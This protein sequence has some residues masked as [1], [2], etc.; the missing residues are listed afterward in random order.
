MSDGEASHRFLKLTAGVMLRGI[1][2][3]RLYFL[4]LSM[5]RHKKINSRDLDC[6]ISL[7]C[8]SI[9]LYADNI[10]LVAPS[11]HMLSEMLNCCETELMWLDMRINAKKS[12]RIRSGPRY[13]ADCF[14]LLT[15]GGDII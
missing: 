7:Q 15:A 5:T 4:F 9:Y 8:T 11:V 13:D 10:L 1:L 3:P 14:Q 2:S 12:A 6:H